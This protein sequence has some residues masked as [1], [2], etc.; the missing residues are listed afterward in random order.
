MNAK[1]AAT[2]KKTKMTQG[3]SSKNSSHKAIVIN[4]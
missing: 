2:L 3:T 4:E 1:T